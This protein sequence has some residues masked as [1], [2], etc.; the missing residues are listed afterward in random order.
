M[1]T[2]SPSVKG[3]EVPAVDLG[4]VREMRREL[5]EL[6][7]RINRIVERLEDV[8]PEPT[9]PQPPS[10]QAGNLINMSTFP[11]FP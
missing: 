1:L 7:D 2:H 5:V 11:H 4:T 9:P 10:K 6:R 8:Y 3:R